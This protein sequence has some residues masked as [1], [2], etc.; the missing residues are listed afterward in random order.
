[1]EHTEQFADEKKEIPALIESKY[2][3]EMAS[4]SETVMCVRVGIKGI[5]SAFFFFF[6]SML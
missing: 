3:K 2:S 6:L 5:Y 4:K 1:M